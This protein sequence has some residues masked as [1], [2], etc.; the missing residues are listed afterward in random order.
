M[1][2]QKRVK[3][4]LYDVLCKIPKILIGTLEWSKNSTFSQ[5]VCFPGSLWKRD[6]ES[7]DG[8]E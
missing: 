4:R 3:R 8:S 1:T 7:E 6:G 2:G 5:F